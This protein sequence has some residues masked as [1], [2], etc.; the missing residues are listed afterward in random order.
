MK[1]QILCCLLAATIILTGCKTNTL[2]P[3]LPDPAVFVGKWIGYASS[4]IIPESSGKDTIILVLNPKNSTQLI[5]TFNNRNI[6][7]TVT[8]SK[9]YIKADVKTS[10][11]LNDSFVAV[12]ITDTKG[13]LSDDSKTISESRVATY[14]VGDRVESSSSSGSTTYVKQK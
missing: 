8:E 11:I 3:D 5:D 4:K 1:K 9:R 7:Y 10:Y 6:I 13:I 2:T 12:T 14:K